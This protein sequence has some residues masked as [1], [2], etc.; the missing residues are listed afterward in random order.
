MQ[1]QLPIFILALLIHTGIFLTSGK[2]DKKL[3]FMAG[4]AVLFNTWPMWYGG[5]LLNE[6]PSSWLMWLGKVMSFSPYFLPLASFL[7]YL[8]KN[9]VA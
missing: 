2:S 6:S 4:L 9:S 8:R 3:R 5:Y 1:V 7:V